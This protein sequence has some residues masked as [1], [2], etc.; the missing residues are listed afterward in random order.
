MSLFAGLI[1][2]QQGPAHP[3]L[4]RFERSAPNL[5]YA[6]IRK[7]TLNDGTGIKTY[8]ERVLR[9]GLNVRIEFGEDSPFSGQYVIEN[10]RERLH[11]VPGLN[12]VRVLVPRRDDTSLF[13]FR[14]RLMGGRPGVTEA[15]GGSIAGIATKR[16]D[17]TDA[18]GRPL[19]KLWIDPARGAILKREVYDALGNL[20]G[21]FEFSRI[22][23]DAEINASAFD[24]S[25]LPGRRV[26]PQEMLRRSA[27]QAQLPMAMIPP[28]S[29]FALDSARP[30]SLGD[31]AAMLMELY[32]SADSRI[33]VY[34]LRGAIN[35][36]RLQRLA[37]GGYSTYST[38]R[39]AYSLVLVGGLAQ[40]DLERL[41][42]TIQ[43]QQP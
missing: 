16:L 14:G 18:Q 10:G 38:Q 5:R 43:L 21:R 17:C 15:N 2:A 40:G 24:T 33:T 42:R 6:G 31:S 36:Q 41:A 23:Y 9:S 34:V 4:Q 22:L 27:Q 13:P 25:R 20:T 7:V 11:V 37:Q 1:T 32:A 28:A 30:I 39:G 8:S 19:Q 29:G 26:N 3:L 12:E 35:R